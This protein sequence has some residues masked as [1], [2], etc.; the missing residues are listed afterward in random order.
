MSEVAA[1]RRTVV[2]SVFALA[3]LAAPLLIWVPPDPGRFLMALGFGADIPAFGW[4]AAALVVV[5]YTAYT[6]WA[7]PEVRV[8]LTP[9]SL[10]SGRWR[11]RLHCCP[12]WSRNTFFRMFVMDSFAGMGMPVVLQVL[13]SALIFAAVHTVWVLFSRSWRVVLPVL[14]STAGL[15]VLL[16][17][18]YLFSDRIVL[19]AVIAHIVINLVIEPGLLLNAAKQA[20]RPASGARQSD[21]P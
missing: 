2:I 9:S 8:R 7:V 5:T 19:P 14:F 4:V 1:R 3:A 17:L 10:G 21:D 13:V 11:S 20:F 6:L 12:V 15:G 18:V 16:A